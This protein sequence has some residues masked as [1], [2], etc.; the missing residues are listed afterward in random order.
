MIRAFFSFLLLLHGLIHLMGFAKAF[1]Y[2]DISQLTQPISKWAGAAWGLTTL[3]FSAVT[4]L[5]L[6]KKE[7][8]W[9]I[10]VVAVLLSQILI[11]SSWQDAKYG[12]LANFLIT[13]AIV[14]AGADWS[15]KHLAT[16]EVQTLISQNNETMEV[17]S[18]AALSSLPPIV[19][20]WLHRSN[21]AGNKAVSTVHLKQKGSMRTTIDGKW[22]PVT[23]EQ[24][25]TTNPPGFLW[26][27]NVEMMPL[28]HL[29]GRD[30]Y[31]DGHGHMLIK[32]L[33]LIPVANAKGPETDQG[34][35][36][37]FLAEIIWFPSAALEP[38]VKWE[39]I[40]ATMAKATMDYGGTVASGIFTFSPEGDMVSFEADRYYNRQGTSSL[41]RWHI[42]ANEWKDFNGAR[43]PSICEVTWKLNEGDFTWFRLEVTDVKYDF[44][45]EMP[46][47][48][49]TIGEPS[50]V[51]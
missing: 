37:R 31:M 42:Q 28:I 12:T 11:L 26:L 21:A 45:E 38:Y 9:M 34:T 27:A 40:S 46:V 49:N 1:N 50:A 5:F 22:M 23:A 17:V 18:D 35:L 6:L 14:C 16:K 48:Q 24:Y 2:A 4:L 36:L 13:I 41:E 15:F 32:A 30:K 25:F 3:L 10:A 29:A 39:S 51:K 7:S 47:I 33:S 8:W 19:R 20:T 43:V 44:T